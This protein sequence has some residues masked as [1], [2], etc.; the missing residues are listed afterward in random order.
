MKH[1]PT[2]AVLFTSLIIVAALAYLVVDRLKTSTDAGGVGR[3]QLVVGP[4]HQ[5]SVL[6]RTDT[7]YGVFKIDTSTGRLWMKVG[8]NWAE[9]AADTEDRYRYMGG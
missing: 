6:D 3:Y 4:Y 7:S 1:T 5:S 9:Q 8:K 2:L